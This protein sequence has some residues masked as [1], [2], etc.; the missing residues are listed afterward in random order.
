M[1]DEEKKCPQGWDQKQLLAYI[2]RDMDNSAREA[3]EAHLKSCRICASEVESLR[4]TDLLLKRHSD[5]FHPDEQRLYRYVTTGDDPE[6]E[7]ARHLERC[8]SC[9]EDA[10]LLKEMIDA[11]SE[12]PAKIPAMPQRLLRRIEQLHPEAASESIFE[13]LYLTAAKLISA[14]FRMPKLALGTAAAL[15]VLAIISIPLW[16]AFK[17]VPLRRFG[18]DSPGIARPEARRDASFGNGP[19]SSGHGKRQVDGKA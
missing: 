2:E 3:L 14:P 7:V 15:V 12:A 11:R 4:K 18:C 19:I 9:Q 16:H 17:N 6:G 10:Q 5:V 1:P 13:R 8:E